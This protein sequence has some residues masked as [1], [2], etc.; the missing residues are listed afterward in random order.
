MATFFDFI[1]SNTQ[2]FQFDPILDGVQHTCIVTWNIF[3]LRFYVNCYDGG[4]NRIFSLPMTGSPP[5]Y[6]ISITAGY[7]KTKLVYRVA[8]NRFEVI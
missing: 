8:E 5:N 1:P 6:D 7:F 4:G 2:A 3:G